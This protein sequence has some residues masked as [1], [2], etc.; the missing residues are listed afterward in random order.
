MDRGCLYVETTAG[1]LD[2]QVIHMTLLLS[3]KIQYVPISRLAE[4]ANPLSP[5]VQ[6]AEWQPFESLKVG[7]HRDLGTGET[8]VALNTVELPARK[9]DS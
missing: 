8:K 1:K 5:L 7:L 3:R 4:Y 2:V 6:T 9:G